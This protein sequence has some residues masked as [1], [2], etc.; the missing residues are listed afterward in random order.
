MDHPRL[1]GWAVLRHLAVP[2][3]ALAVVATLPIARSGDAPTYQPGLAPASV[4]YG[5]PAA[6]NAV[7]GQFL[8]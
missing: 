1:R 7:K 6:G 2:A 3:L 5:L 8:S 4:S